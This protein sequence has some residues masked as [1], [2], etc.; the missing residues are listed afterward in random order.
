[1]NWKIGVLLVVFL[2]SLVYSNEVNF[3][4]EV[5]E[6]NFKACEANFEFRPE[7]N[8]CVCIN[9]PSLYCDYSNNDPDYI[10][11]ECKQRNNDELQCRQNRIA[12]PNEVFDAETCQFKCEDKYIYNQDGLCLSLS[13]GLED[14]LSKYKQFCA[15][16]K[17][18]CEKQCSSTTCRISCNEERTKCLNYEYPSE[19]I[20]SNSCLPIFGL[21]GMSL[22]FVFLE[23]KG[24]GFGF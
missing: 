15:S 20:K 4:M 17:D 13:A 14:A 22:L 2:I 12:R 16:E 10:N 7:F 24:V 23:H 3:S 11:C 19:S 1:M 6:I 8:D 21:V 5:Q 9:D 18:L